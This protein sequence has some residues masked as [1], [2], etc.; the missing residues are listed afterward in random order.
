MEILLPVACGLSLAGGAI[1][2]LSSSRRSALPPCRRPARPNQL[3]LDPLALAHRMAPSGRGWRP[4]RHSLQRSFGCQAT[5]PSPPAGAE[6][7]PA[8]NRSGLNQVLAG[9]QENVLP[10][11]GVVSDG[12]SG[13]L[14][15]IPRGTTSTSPFG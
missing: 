5:W 12:A 10:R 13:S 7:L 2:P 11:P 4:G 8:I 9:D 6:H 14:G 3:N 15:G 1:A